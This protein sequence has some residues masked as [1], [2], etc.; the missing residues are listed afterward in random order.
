V[1]TDLSALYLDVL[2]DRLYTFAPAHP[3]RRSAQTAL[4]R[5]AE[6]LTR[7]IAPI[8]S[9]T[10]DEVWPLLPQVEG[11]E[12]S[13]HLAL[14]PDLAD[15][16]PGNESDLEAEWAQLLVIRDQ[17]LSKLELLRAEKVIG[18]S[19]EA[20]VTIHLSGPQDAA[21]LTKYAHA[22][23]EL[24]NVSHVALK[25]YEEAGRNPLTLYVS[26]S[27]APKCDR[28]W[29]YIPEVG[30]DARFPTV[31]LRCAGALQAIGFAPYSKPNVST[32]PNA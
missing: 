28:C 31:C 8:L 32:E 19:L 30:E 21:V 10:A 12:P 23:A 9:F 17:A 14:F 27:A 25:P 26:K 29:R 24:L 5:I 15:I 1:N 18:K 20:E 22:L 16:I 3:S 13:V 11:R 2:K 4:W 6:A 7:L